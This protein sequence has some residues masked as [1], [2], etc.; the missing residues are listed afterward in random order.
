M[1]HC[2]CDNGRDIESEVLDTLLEHE[3]EKVQLRDLADELDINEEELRATIIRLRSKSAIGVSF[4][5]DTGEL[6]IGELGGRG[7]KTET[8]ANCPYCGYKL[9]PG[10]QFCPNCGSSIQ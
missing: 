4:D 7:V 6:M 2:C 1:G 5:S 8:K 3:E 10:A 9:P